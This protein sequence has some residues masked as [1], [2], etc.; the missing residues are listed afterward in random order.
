MHYKI[1]V[2][3]CVYCGQWTRVIYSVVLTW[4]SNLIHLFH[5]STVRLMNSRVS[6]QCLCTI[7]RLGVYKAD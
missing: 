3:T 1:G 6:G 4:Q 7:H 5:N 2:V